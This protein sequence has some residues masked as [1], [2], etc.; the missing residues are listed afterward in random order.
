MGEHKT[1]LKSAGEISES[2]AH[3]TEQWPGRVLGNKFFVTKTIPVA[4]T[5]TWCGAKLR[6]DKPQR[7]KIWKQ[8]PANKTRTKYTYTLHYCTD[9]VLQIYKLTLRAKGP[10][11]DQPIKRFGKLRVH[12][13]AGHSFQA[14]VT[15]TR[16]PNQGASTVGIVK[17]RVGR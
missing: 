7:G 4:V 6:A 5:A 9:T 1:T 17:E 16:W 15:H 10:D 14:L 12:G 3:N 11:G 2:D 8:M 13:A